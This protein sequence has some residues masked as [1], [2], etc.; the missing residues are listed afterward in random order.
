MCLTAFPLNQIEGSGIAKKPAIILE[1]E[2][3]DDISVPDNLKYKMRQV[4]NRHG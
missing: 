4:M 2:Y 1:A 3:V